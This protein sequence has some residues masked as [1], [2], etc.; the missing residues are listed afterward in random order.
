MPPH[1][2]QV[3]QT[4]EKAT[5]VNLAS[6]LITDCFL[7]DF[8]DAVVISNDADLTTPIEIVTKQFGKLVTAIN[9]HRKRYLSQ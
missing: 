4:K 3:Q 8:V 1:P 6:L 2:V 9:P 5:D 7:N